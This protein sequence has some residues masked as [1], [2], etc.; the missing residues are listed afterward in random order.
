MRVRNR[1]RIAGREHRRSIGVGNA[2]SWTLEL[3]PEGLHAHRADLEVAAVGLV[4]EL[5]RLAADDLGRDLETEPRVEAMTPS[6]I[7]PVRKLRDLRNSRISL[8]RPARVYP[9]GFVAA[10]ARYYGLHQWICWRP[11]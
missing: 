2:R 5:D 6:T 4:D 1:R 8:P 3:Q 9:G 10:R 11:P 7:A